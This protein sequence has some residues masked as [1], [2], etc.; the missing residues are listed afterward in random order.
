MKCKN[1]TLTTENPKFCSR[2]CAAS[3][4]NRKYPKRYN[5]NLRRECKLCEALLRR[6]GK[7]TFCNMVC[8]HEFHYQR[9]KDSVIKSGIFTF[10][11]NTASPACRHKR[12]LTEFHGWKCQICD[13]KTWLGAPINLVFDHI[14]GNSDNWKVTNCRLVCNNCDSTLPTYKGRNIGNGSPTT[15]QSR[16]YKWSYGVTGEHAT[17]LKWAIGVRI[18]VGLLMRYYFKY[19]VRQST[20]SSLSI[21]T[22]NPIPHFWK[23]DLDSPGDGWVRVSAHSDSILCVIQKSAQCGF[24]SSMFAKITGR[25]LEAEIICQTCRDLD[26]PMSTD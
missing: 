21:R 25:D 9:W 12:F 13:R 14:D 7:A 1:C 16:R 11:H 10:A 3:F 4:N 19:F 5:A 2:T 23:N 18:P 26:G 24:T 6:P 20:S 22:T 8:Y 15:R 17:L